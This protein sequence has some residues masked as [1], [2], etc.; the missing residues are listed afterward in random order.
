MKPIGIALIV[1]G[2]VAL[3]Y[4]GIGYQREK[5]IIDMGPIKATTTEHHSIPVSPI[6][7]T[8]ALVGGI[9]L[10]LTPSRRLQ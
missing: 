9:L 7:G 3:V 10:V 5:T 2:V 6:A 1:L 8:I 4:G